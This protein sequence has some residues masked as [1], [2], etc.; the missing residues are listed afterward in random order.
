MSVTCVESLHD[1]R[2]AGNQISS[3]KVTKHLYTMLYLLCHHT[4]IIMTG[5][6]VC[7]EQWWRE[8]MTQCPVC[9]QGFYK[10][11]VE[12]YFDTRDVCKNFWKFC[13]ENHAFFRCQTVKR[14]PRSHGNL[15]SRGSSFRLELLAHIGWPICDWDLNWDLSTF[16]N[17]I[18][19]IKT[20]FKMAQ[21][22]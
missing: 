3:L 5:W 21:F 17:S 15:M 18:W 1:S 8:P 2:M 9:V 20:P 4:V 14:L 6:W 22:D 19:S 13:L 16:G 10:D 7:L 11:T 12:F